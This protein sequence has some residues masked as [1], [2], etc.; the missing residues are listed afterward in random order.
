DRNWMGPPMGKIIDMRKA[1][2]A[3]DRAATGKNQPGRLELEKPRVKS[4]MMTHVD[5]DHDRSE[6]VITFIGGKNYA[7]LQGPPAIYD[8]LLE[9][10]SKGAFFNEYIKDKFEY[11]DV[12]SRP[13]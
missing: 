13:R 6:L 4:S 10:D 9:A 5:Y 7:D 8:G 1:Q 11:R 12:V 2:A 3:L